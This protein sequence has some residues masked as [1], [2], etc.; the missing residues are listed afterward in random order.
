MIFFFIRIYAYS[1]NNV[2]MFET[3][4]KIVMGNNFFYLNM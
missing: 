2:I 1:L 4:N 3:G